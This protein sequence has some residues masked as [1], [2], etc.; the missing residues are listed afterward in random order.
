LACFSP[1]ISGIS[2]K[3]KG[4]KEGKEGIEGEREGRREI[5]IKNE[6]L[7]TIPKSVP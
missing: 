1:Q 4:R 7:K 5:L 6:N 2:A 3:S